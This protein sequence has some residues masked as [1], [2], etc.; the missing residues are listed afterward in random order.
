MPKPLILIS[1]D[2]DK[3]SHFIKKTYC[4][5]IKAAGGEVVI[6]PVCS[7]ETTEKL[8]SI[9]DGLLLSGGNDVNPEKY[10]ENVAPHN[11]GTIDTPRD[12]LEHKLLEEALQRN[13]PILG[14]C[15]GNQ[16]LNVH[17]GG[18]LFQD[19]PVEVSG[20]ISHQSDF[21]QTG[22]YETHEISIVSD[23]LLA[24]ILNKQ[25]IITNSIHHQAIKEVGAHLRINA[26]ATDGVI[27][28]IEHISYP[29][30]VGV[31]WH[32]EI[33][34]DRNSAEI[35]KAFISAAQLRNKNISSAE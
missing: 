31:Q 5:A 21:A 2:T 18:T 34:D 30:L 11:H 23:S 7:D 28:G 3:E 25:Q 13:L 17:F 6:M 8:L 24:S 33:L 20:A 9:A 22:S 32:P 15:R 26:R 1:A 10:R 35:F 27:E 29:F 14:I 16:V 12:N 19:I 4:A